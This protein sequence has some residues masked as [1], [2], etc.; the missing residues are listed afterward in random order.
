ME[1]QL[2]ITTDHLSLAKV[3]VAGSDPEEGLG[4]GEI[5]DGAL[6]GRYWCCRGVLP[7]EAAGEAQPRPAKLLWSGSA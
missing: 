4:T 1:E 6:F 2:V 7:T 5:G 3:V